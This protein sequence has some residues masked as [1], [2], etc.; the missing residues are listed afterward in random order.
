VNTAK[1]RY[2]FLM[3]F[4]TQHFISPLYRT[5]IIIHLWS[6]HVCHRGSPGSFPGSVNLGFV[7]DKVEPGR[8]FFLVFRFSPVGHVSSRLHTHSFTYHRRNI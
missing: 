7:V 1:I 5:F 8:D 4:T 6:C 2:Y 3:S